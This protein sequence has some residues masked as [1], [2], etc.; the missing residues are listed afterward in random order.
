MGYGA[1]VAR[2]GFRSTF[3]R[4]QGKQAE[5]GHAAGC[6]HHFTHCRHRYS[7]RHFCRLCSGHRHS[8]RLRVRLTPTHH[9]HHHAGPQ[10]EPGRRRLRADGGPQYG[11][12]TFRP[13]NSTLQRRSFATSCLRLHGRR[14][15]ATSLQ[16]QVRG[17]KPE[18]RRLT[19]DASAYGGGGCPAG[20][21]VAA[22]VV[23]VAAAGAPSTIVR[24]SLLVTGRSAAAAAGYLPGW[25]RSLG[26]LPSAVQK[27]LRSAADQPR[28]PVPAAELF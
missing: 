26:H 4:L 25:Q 1:G 8:A 11:R 15:G 23:A 12:R 5:L 21:P 18:G 9:P 22:A 14:S 27:Y 17:L 7:G 10:P 19:S 2:N 24:E 3:R 16:S 13:H 28:L 6:C 20:A